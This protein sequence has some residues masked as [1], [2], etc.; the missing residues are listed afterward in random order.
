MAT[1]TI[2]TNGSGRVSIRPKQMKIGFEISGCG[3]QAIGAYQTAAVRAT[4]LR[5]RLQEVG[6]DSVQV[7]TV[8]CTVRH[9]SDRFDA[10]C[11]DPTYRAVKT[12]VV[13]CRPDHARDVVMG[14]IETGA[15]VVENR[16]K[17]SER[18]RS[19]ARSEALT[20]ATNQARNHAEAIAAAE[21][22]ELDQAL[23]VTEEHP[24]GMQDLVDDALETVDTHHVRPRPIEISARVTVSY[25]ITDS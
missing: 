24:E 20:K 12:I 15:S 4:A 18:R 8:D 10:S 22:V 21:G 6:S 9:R 14:G 7:E 13:K 17:L 11:D 2:T 23:E 19:K 3:E 16:S 5:E 1:R 25:A